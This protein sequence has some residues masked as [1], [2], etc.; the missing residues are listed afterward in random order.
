VKKNQL[1]RRLLIGGLA[2]FLLAMAILLAPFPFIRTLWDAEILRNRMTWDLSQRLDG[3][4]QEDI[5]RIL[6]EPEQ[7][8]PAWLSRTRP[9]P[10]WMYRVHPDRHRYMV[11]FFDEDGFAGHIE[12]GYPESSSFKLNLIDLEI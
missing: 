6:G 8:A 9:V 10:P 12:V 5:I 1:K 11:I 2:V 7:D 4:H 3:L